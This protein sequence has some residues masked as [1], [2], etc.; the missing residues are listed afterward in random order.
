MMEVDAI[1]RAAFD[2]WEVR[3]RRRWV[4]CY[5]QYEMFIHPPGGLPDI[6]VF[7]DMPVV[8]DMDRLPSKTNHVKWLSVKR[9]PQKGFD[10]NK[11][12]V[13]LINGTMA[14]IDR[15]WPLVARLTMEGI[16]AAEAY[17][18]TAAARE[19]AGLYRDVGIIG[20]VLGDM[21]YKDDIEM[22]LTSRFGK[23]TKLTFKRQ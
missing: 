1:A 6:G 7:D 20:I 11:Y 5:G 18:S 10:K 22:A 19:T 4:V 2:T 9:N 16:L 23:F 8:K 13:F 12:G 14:E 17:A 21:D 15:L 3:S